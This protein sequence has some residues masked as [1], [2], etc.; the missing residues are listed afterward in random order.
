MIDPNMPAFPMPDTFLKDSFDAGTATKLREA[1]LGVPVRLWLAAQAMQGLLA[2]H[3]GSES[4][5]FQP[6]YNE[7]GWEEKLSDHSFKAADALLSQYNRTE[8]NGA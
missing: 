8:T 6:F 7:T 3:L 5:D 4:G 2:Q 1:N